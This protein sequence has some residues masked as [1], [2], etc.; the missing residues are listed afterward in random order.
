M[1]EIRLKK[2]MANLHVVHEAGR[3]LA[4]IERAHF[5]WCAGCD[6]KVIEEKPV[7]RGGSARDWP[8]GSSRGLPGGC[9]GPDSRQAAAPETQRLLYIRSI[10]VV[11][12]WS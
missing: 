5:R 12:F 3:L 4:A 7:L 11:R 8:Q 1:H 9:W 2:C 10:A 6:G